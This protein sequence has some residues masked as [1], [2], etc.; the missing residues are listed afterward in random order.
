MTGI[1][2]M[3]G[4][5]GDPPLR[6]C[7]PIA[8]LFAAHFAV[9]G[10]LASLVARGRTGAGEHVEVPMFDTMLSMLT[11]T[12]TLYLNEAKEPMRMGSEHEYSIPWQAV[13]ASDGSFVLAVRA[14][15]FW[16]RL[17]HAI[18]KEEWLTDHRFSTNERRLQHRAQLAELM[19]EAFCRESVA[20]WTDRLR[21]LGVP[22]AP[23]RTVGEALDEVRAQGSELITAFEQPGYGRFE[24]IGNPV[25]FTHMAKAV[26]AAAPTLDEYVVDGVL[27]EDPR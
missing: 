25:R 11:Y 1:M 23:V 10:V 24:V 22:T 8:D 21:A 20:F 26:P 4:V 27:A 14:E 6:V 3:E 16:H 15:K 7:L 19:D 9:Y 12:A 2:L 13:R 5:A 17:C 18:G